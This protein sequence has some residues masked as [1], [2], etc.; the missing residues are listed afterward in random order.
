MK[1][2]IPGK[3]VLVLLAGLLVAGGC[4]PPPAPPQPIQMK[5]IVPPAA[6][7]LM[8][9]LA[10]AY[11]SR[12]S[13]VQFEISKANAPAALAAVAA[14]EA[15]LAIV[16]RALEPAELLNPEDAR[17]SLTAWP[18][19]LDGL[20]V[21]VNPSNP[22]TSLTRPQL[23]QIFEGLEQRWSAL[24][25]PDTAIRL[26]SRE[27]GAVA[28][29]S[30]EE[31]IL[32]GGRLAGTAVIMPSDQAVADYVAKHPEAIGYVSMAWV[33]AGVKAIGLDGT[34]P[35]PGTVARG[36]YPLR[37]PLVIVTPVAV[38]DKARAFIDFV[39]GDGRNIVAER[40]APAP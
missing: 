37:H 31:G 36:S 28:R 8:E 18:L 11:R 3:F 23:R 15:D 14:H 1:Q 2:G 33:Q 13:Y 40:Y 19:A 4:A 21:I 38:A 22:L 20:A 39:R 30:F 17:P 29:L 6:A 12:R 35:T 24:G 34:L 26:V 16:E 27:P 5:V 7:P 9:K 32:Q 10:A 25:G